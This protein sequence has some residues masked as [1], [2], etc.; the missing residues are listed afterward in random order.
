MQGTQ[1]TQ[2]QDNEVVPDTDGRT[3]L[4]ITYHNFSRNGHYSDNYSPREVGLHQHS[5]GI[6]EGDEENALASNRETGEHMH[7]D[8]TVVEGDDDDSNSESE[9]DSDNE[10][11]IIDFQFAMDGI[12]IYND[13][14]ILID[15]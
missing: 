11:V 9:E 15:T 12:G 7:M 8:G 10:S 1:F 2:G 13:R 4:W 3:E 14:S 5:S 6:E